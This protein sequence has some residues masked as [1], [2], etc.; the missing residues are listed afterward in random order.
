M[1]IHACSRNGVGDVDA[2]DRANCARQGIQ[3]LVAAFALYLLSG[4]ASAHMT[5]LYMLSG[6]VWAHMAQASPV[7]IVQVLQALAAVSAI[8]STIQTFLS[9]KPSLPDLANP[10]G[11][12]RPIQVGADHD[13]EDNKSF[14]LSNLK[15][16]RSLAIGGSRNVLVIP[17]GGL[18]NIAIIFACGIL[19]GSLSPRIGETVIFIASM[20]GAVVSI[21]NRI[22]SGNATACNT[23]SFAEKESAEDYM[24]SHMCE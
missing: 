4:V 6:A 1:G 19:I 13:V 24:L 17:M 22:A 7:V 9:A 20:R 5:Q 14:V 21:W 8:A 11:G 18:R 12:L 16:Q 10:I 23:K 2:L 3:L 15:D